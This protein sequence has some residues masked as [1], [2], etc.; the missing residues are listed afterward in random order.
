MLE[1]TLG[2]ED[3]EGGSTYSKTGYTNHQACL[4]EM[5]WER[6]NIVLGKCNLKSL[7]RRD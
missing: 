4:S 1:P 7:I 3:I 5:K 2:D 6:K